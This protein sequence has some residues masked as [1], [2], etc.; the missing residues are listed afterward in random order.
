MTSSLLFNSVRQLQI[1][2]LMQDISDHKYDPQPSGTH[3]PEGQHGLR[4]RIKRSALLIQEAA[5]QM[6]PVDDGCIRYRL[7][8]E[9]YSSKLSMIEQRAILM[10]AFRMWSEVCPI[11][12]VEDLTSNAEDLDI[13][14]IFGK[15]ESM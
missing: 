15:G 12:F 5:G 7:L 13:Q 3:N 8:V 14:I 4:Q 1:H 6:F 11:C 10:L 2:N 9:G